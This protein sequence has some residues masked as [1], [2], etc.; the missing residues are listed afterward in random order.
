LDYELY[1]NETKT[2]LVALYDPTSST[3]Q[4]RYL[5]SSVVAINVPGIVLSAG[6]QK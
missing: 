5:V 6:E 3:E 2:S 1:E 4:S